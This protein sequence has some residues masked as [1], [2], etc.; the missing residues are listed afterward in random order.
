MPWSR[1]ARVFEPANE[2]RP[3]RVDVLRAGRDV[4]PRIEEA[5]AF[6]P[7][8]EQEGFSLVD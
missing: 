2:T 4:R 7:H 3:A 1:R 6:D 5:F 8:F